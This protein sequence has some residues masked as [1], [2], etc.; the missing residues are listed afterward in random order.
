MLEI[1]KITFGK[2]LKELRLKQNLTQLEVSILLGISRQSIS[3]W[4][5]DISL[6]LVTYIVP[7]SKIYCCSIEDFFIVYER[8]EE[9]D[10]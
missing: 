5:Q 2:N 8:E 7:L 4:E 3:K 6:P 9:Q 1:I 10:E